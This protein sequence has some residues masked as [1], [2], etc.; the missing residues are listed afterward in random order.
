[1]AMSSLREKFV[2]AL[3]VASCGTPPPA[4][5]P[6]V[7][8]A[9]A[10]PVLIVDDRRPVLER[11]E[12]SHAALELDFFD[13]SVAGPIVRGLSLPLGRRARG[14]NSLDDVPD[15]A[16]FTNRIGVRDMTPEEIAR[17]PEEGDGPDQHKPWTIV[18]NKPGGTQVGFIIRDARGVKYGIGFDMPEW[19]ELKTGT[20]V[21]LNR[22]LWAFGYNVPDDRVAFVRPEELVVSPDAETKDTHGR[23]LRR[24]DRK[25]VDRL[26]AQVWH[27]PDGRIRVFASRWLE[28]ESLGGTD[29]SGVRDGDP[30]DRIPH[31]DRRDLR[32]MYP[33]FAW[34]QHLDLVRGNFLDM[35]VARPDDPS[36]RYVKHY[37][38]D[39]SRGLGAGAVIEH[40]LR[41]NYQ[42][43]IDGSEPGWAFGLWPRPWGQYWAPKLTGVSP[44]FAADG[45]DPGAWKPDIPYMPF[46]EG[47]RFDSFWG[48]KVLAHFTRDQIR[49]AVQAGQ[50]SDPR[51]I[52]YLTDTLIARQRATVAYWYA[53]VNP[54]DKF[55]TAPNGLCFQDLAIAAGLAAAAQTKYELA[56][57]DREAR[58]IG[59]ILVDAAPSGTTCTTAVQVTVG[60][61][62]YTMVKITTQRP[63]FAGSTVVHLARTPE[64]GAWR[65]IGVWRM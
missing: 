36:H 42:Y 64:T 4:E 1:M 35:L 40:D 8:F 53:R 25:E 33:L 34:L 16:W 37:L 15:S 50:F 63:A 6:R 41:S 3:A 60:T 30:N 31:E 23:K 13:R 48:T 46:T 7:R 38:L 22:L 24:L 12:V 43:L 55:A 65:V 44:T 39:F 19:P 21:V 62:S 52:D 56:S 18:S 29:P 17:G 11:P 57:Y 2:I 32:G 58:P 49:A 10:V 28:G 9:N 61:D 51:T 5:V 20:A 59:R 47:D 27:E 54:L 14:M 26:L 45:F